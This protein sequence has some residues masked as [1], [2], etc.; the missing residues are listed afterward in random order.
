MATGKKIFY[1]HAEFQ[2]PAPC[3]RAVA[4]RIAAVKRR[5]N[6]KHRSDLDVVSRSITIMFL[7]DYHHSIECSRLVS[8]SVDELATGY[9]ARGQRG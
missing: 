6:D 2:Q 7:Y 3:L 4:K 8:I 9:P 1:F 5:M